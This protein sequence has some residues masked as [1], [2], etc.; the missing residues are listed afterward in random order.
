[1]WNVDA[2]FQDSWFGVT[3]GVALRGDKNR[4]D[5]LWQ[6]LK[7]FWRDE[8]GNERRV[9]A[10]DPGVQVHVFRTADSRVATVCILAVWDTPRC[11]GGIHGIRLAEA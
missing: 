5:D 3:S 2:A 7:P 9:G 11:T 1:M 10:R 4:Y 6:L 8:E